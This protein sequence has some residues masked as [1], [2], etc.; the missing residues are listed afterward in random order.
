MGWAWASA[1]CGLKPLFTQS[2]NASRIDGPDSLPQA[3]AMT[4]ACA[5]CWR[6]LRRPASAGGIDLSFMNLPFV[7]RPQPYQHKF[8]T[9]LAPQR[10]AVSVQLLVETVA[11]SWRAGSFQLATEHPARLHAPVV[12]RA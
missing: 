6:K 10:A 7:S 9:K 12:G 11:L 4:A 1:A 8:L 3:A 5:D 2:E